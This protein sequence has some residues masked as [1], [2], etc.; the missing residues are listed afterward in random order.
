ML[1]NAKFK[2]SR[3]QD[4]NSYV[5]ISKVI[6]VDTNMYCNYGE[7]DNKDG[8]LLYLPLSKVSCWSCS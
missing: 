3:N 2:V 6:K 5:I 7:Q 1:P 4:N 8:L